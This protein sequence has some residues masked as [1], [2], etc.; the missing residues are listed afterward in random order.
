M[1]FLHIAVLCGLAAGL[2]LPSLAAPAK[3]T[4]ATAAT[5]A[6]TGTV[7]AIE[8]EFDMAYKALEQGQPAVA[9]GLFR[10][11]LQKQPLNRRGRFGLSTALIQ[12]DQYKDALEILEVMLKE[13]PKDYVLKNNTAWIYATV[14]DVKIRNGARAIQLAQEALL[15]NPIDCHVW[16]TLAEAYYI[17]GRYEKALRSANE[18]LRVGRETNADAKLMAQYQAQDERCRKAAATS[19]ILE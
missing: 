14:R 10:K 7:S 12:T 15:L 17:S 6:T 2:L 1:K 11:A 18:A 16:S 5:T 19:S 8:K 9:V 4:Q 3:S 13:T